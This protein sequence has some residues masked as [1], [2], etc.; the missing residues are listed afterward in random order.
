[1][2]EDSLGTRRDV[3]LAKSLERYNWCVLASYALLLNYGHSEAG[4]LIS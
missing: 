2:L 3:R 1:M 4:V